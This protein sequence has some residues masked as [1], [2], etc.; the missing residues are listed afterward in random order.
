MTLL[1]S[2]RAYLHTLRCTQLCQNEKSTMLGAVFGVRISVK[3]PGKRDAAR[4]FGATMHKRDK[5][6]KFLG[7]YDN[8]KISFGKSDGRE[9]RCCGE[10]KSLT[11]SL[12]EKVIHKLA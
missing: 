4:L 7:Q 6:I 1:C 11:Q 5:V 9:C 12:V 8:K 3:E 10:E 2:A